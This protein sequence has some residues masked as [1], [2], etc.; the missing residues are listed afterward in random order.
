M[1]Q[2]D[3]NVRLRHMLDYAHE[4]IQMVQDKSRTDL[5]SDRLLSLALVR[6]MEV[7]GEAAARVPQNDKEKYK[8]IEWSGIVGLR[9]RLIHGYDVINL[10]LLWVI[11]QKDIPPLIEALENIPDVI[12][13]SDD[14]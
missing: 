12:A 2:H 1:T 3:T 4:A 14:I 11:I 7:I 13:L 8:D 5:D 9:N 10:D 6:V